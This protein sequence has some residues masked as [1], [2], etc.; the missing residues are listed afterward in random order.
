MFLF[1]FSLI[2]VSVSCG[3]CDL[4]VI[5]VIVIDGVIVDEL[6]MMLMWFFVMSLCV[7][8]V[9]VFGLE[10]LFIIMRCSFFL[11]MVFG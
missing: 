9:L 7:R 1:G 2:G 6:M 4:V 5:L 10:V 3:V 11:V 8:C